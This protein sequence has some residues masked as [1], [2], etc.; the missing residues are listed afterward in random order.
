MVALLLLA[1]SLA[2]TSCTKEEGKRFRL[3]VDGP[4]KTFL[5][6]NHITFWSQG[7]ALYVNGDNFVT[8]SETGSDT[9]A[10]S[11]VVIA[12]IN[13]KFYAFYGGRATN[14]NTRMV[15]PASQKFG[16]SMSDNYTYDASVLNSPMAGVGEEGGNVTILFS[17]LFSLLELSVPIANSTNSY[18]ITI[19]ELD[20]T[21]NM[22]LAGDFESEYTADGWST[23]CTGNASYTLTVQKSTSGTEIYVPIPSGS[24][25]LK[26]Q[27]VSNLVTLGKAEMTS[28]SYTFKAGCYYKIST[29]PQTPENAPLLPYPVSDGSN[30]YFFGKGNMSYDH[31]RN[32]KWILETNQWDITIYHITSNSATDPTGYS[33]LLA[34]MP[35][36]TG[37]PA[38]LNN[39]ISNGPLVAGGYARLLGEDATLLNTWHVPTQAQWESILGLGTGQTAKWGYVRINNGGTI[40]KGLIILP[41]PSLATTYGI[42]LGT[43][44]TY[45]AT[46]SEVPL[47]ASAQFL[48][49]ETLGAIFLPVTGY[50]EIKGNSGQY[51]D[52]GYG[53]YRAATNVNGANSKVLQFRCDMFPTASAEKKYGEGVAVRLMRIISQ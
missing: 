51:N 43:T 15:L 53:Y 46:W 45:N 22:P 20:P 36:T 26:I 23:I 24:H 49:L 14:I 11:D 12:P 28:Q 47:I 32:P 33:G 18:S 25:K 39:S 16:Y 7:D 5:G 41:D 10:Q 30:A 3:V 44:Y 50:A 29:L 6:T 2:I 1:G 40:Y 52:D 34:W 35:S 27:V 4:E 37:N 42:S 9:Y 8:V 19:T 48:E 31:D 21:N 38:A 17:N 13:N